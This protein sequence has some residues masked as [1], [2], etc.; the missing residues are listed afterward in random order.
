MPLQSVRTHYAGL[1]QPHRIV[2]LVRRPEN[3]F[4]RFGQG[5]VL[6]A[7]NVRRAQ[8]VGTRSVSSWNQFSTKIS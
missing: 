1:R 8:L 7:M 4:A 5:D 2:W 3:P 6:H